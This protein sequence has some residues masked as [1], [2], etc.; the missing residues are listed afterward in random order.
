[1]ILIIIGND[2]C[3]QTSRQKVICI[4][5]QLVGAILIASIFGSMSAEIQ[6]V[7]DHEMQH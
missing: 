5:I 4:V 7:Q 6:R 2:I 1:M 3:P